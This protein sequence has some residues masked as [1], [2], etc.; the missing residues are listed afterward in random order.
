ML[1][2]CP[3]V[4]SVQ[5][6]KMDRRLKK[7]RLWKIQGRE[8]GP[9]KSEFLQSS[10]P[11]GGVGNSLD[12]ACNINAAGIPSWGQILDFHWSSRQ[13]MENC[14]EAVISTLPV[15]VRSRLPKNVARFDES[16]RISLYR[17]V[18]NAGERN[19]TLLDENSS[20]VLLLL[21]LQTFAFFP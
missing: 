11:R 15:F 3:Y 6:H 17:A 9:P 10:A 16:D 12:L 1:S 13:K 4:C 20:A 8:A 21:L 19:E 2:S 7:A 18:Q 14:A 5:E